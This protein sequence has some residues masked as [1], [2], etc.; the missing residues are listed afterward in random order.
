VSESAI[1]VL[2]VDDHAVVRRGIQA[3]LATEPGI[4][5][6]GEATNGVEAVARAEELAPD[7]VL[8]DIKMPEMDGIEA[9]R[10]IRGKNPA[11]QILVL[12]SFSSDAKLFPAV[13]AGA[14]GYLL[15]SA[16]PDELIR[17]I[18]NSAAGRTSLTPDVG[19][20]LLAEFSRD[21]PATPLAEPLT[22]R[23][24]DMLK[25]LARGLSNEQIADTLHVSEA[26]VRTHVSHILSKLNLANRTQAALYALREGLASLEDVPH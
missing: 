21:E 19:R 2:L 15:K 23:E 3:L 1:R 12:T 11:I 10:M 7:V 14:V 25:Q 22:S 13:K 8:M 20:R 4:E 18:R 17:G 6:V 26:T 24:I 5:V 9:M 16:T